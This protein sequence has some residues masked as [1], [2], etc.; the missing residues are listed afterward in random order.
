MSAPAARHAPSA[1][2]LLRRQFRLA[3]D[4]LD[5]AT[6]RLTIEAAHRRP[7][8]AAA[9]AG[10]CY[11][12]VV[13]C[14][15]LSVNGVLAARSPLAHSTWLGRTGISELPPLAGSTDW[16]AWAH[17]VQLDLAV[18]RPYARAV[19]AA[20]DAYLAA[21]PGEALDSESGEPPMCLL[22]ALL[23]TLA[24]RRGEISCLAALDRP[25]AAGAPM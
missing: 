17:R 5:A 12:Q 13:L 3:H 10:A 21:L 24:M 9:P 16:R 23:L 14:E 1:G 15:D 25:P 6:D 11:A 8:G 20:T 2:A 19:Y 22:S 7:P 4:L 18:L